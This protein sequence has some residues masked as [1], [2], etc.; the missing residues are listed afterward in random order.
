V[1]PLLWAIPPVAAAVGAGIALVQLGGIEAAAG[2]LRAELV[3]FR[4]VHTA[5]AEVRAA[6]DRTATLRQGLDRG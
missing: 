3:R 2:D 6:T 5:V 4:A 1:T